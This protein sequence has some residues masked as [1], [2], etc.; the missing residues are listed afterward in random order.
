MY[1]RINMSMNPVYKF[2]NIHHITMILEILLVP[3]YTSIRADLEIR[4]SQHSGWPGMLA[5]REVQMF[6]LAIRVSSKVD[7]Q[8]SH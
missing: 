1:I 5:L 6:S 7:C 3:L 8:R 2:R 4:L